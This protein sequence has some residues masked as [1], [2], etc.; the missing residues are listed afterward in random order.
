MV[1][2][3]ETLPLATDLAADGRTARE[4]NQVLLVLYSRAGCSWCHKARTHSL[5]ALSNDPTVRERVIVRQ[6]DE[7]SPASLVDFAGRKTTHRAFAR[8]QRVRLV[9]TVMFLDADG[10]SLA[11]PLVGFKGGVEFYDLYVRRSL[12]A[13]QARLNERKND[14]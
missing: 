2:A 1:R 14:D 7:D 6:I 4:K 8:Q 3:A 12:E 13:A 10:T 5:V 11:E 9:P